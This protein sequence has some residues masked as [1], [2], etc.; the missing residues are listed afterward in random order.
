MPA[1]PSTSDDVPRLSFAQAV[2]T[3]DE[4]SWAVI[5]LD[6]GTVLGTNIVL[7]PFPTQDE[8][9]CDALTSSDS[10]ALAYAEQHGV[11]LYRLDD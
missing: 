9:W 10:D 5:D 11:T 2:Q 3:L 6:S 7:V 1:E 8:E 4:H